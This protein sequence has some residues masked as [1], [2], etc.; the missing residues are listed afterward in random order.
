MLL[1]RR[2]NQIS[3]GK[4]ANQISIGK[5]FFSSPPRASRTEGMLIIAAFILAISVCNICIWICVCAIWFCVCAI[6]FIICFRFGSSSASASDG[7]GD[8][9]AEGNCSSPFSLSVCDLKP[10]R[11]ILKHANDQLKC[12]L[13]SQQD[14]NGKKLSVTATIDY[15]KS[16]P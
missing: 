16:N 11:V 10:S 9:C 14:F 4:G 6:S 15:H 1:G 3:I 5:G 8:N 12:Q 7:V 13:Q 2:R